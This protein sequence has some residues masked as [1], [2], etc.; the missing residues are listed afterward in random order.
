[1]SHKFK[2]LCTVCGI[3]PVAMTRVEFC[4]HCWPGG[5][6]TPPPCLRCGSRTNYY[7]SGLCTRCHPSATPPVESCRDCL[8]W[9]A[10]RM[11]DWLCRGCNSWRRQHPT[12]RACCICGT[13]VPVDVDGAC[14]LCHRQATMMRVDHQLLDLIGAN[15]D[16]QQLF[17]ADLFSAGSRVRRPRPVQGQDPSPV[18]RHIPAFVQLTLF[19]AAR[20]LAAHGR[21]GLA[22]RCDPVVAA[23]IDEYVAAHAA[24]HGWTPKAT[25]NTA[26]GIRILRGLQDDPDTPIKAS[27]VELLRTIDMDTERIFEILTDT[28]E[29]DD[30][31]VR[32]VDNW[33]TAKTVNLPPKIREELGVWFAVMRDGSTVPPR[34][35]PRSH[36]SINYQL[37]AALPAIGVWVDRGCTTLAE[38]TR[39]D[40]VDVLPIE[41]NPRAACGQGLKSIFAV[42]KQHK[43]VFTNPAAR[44]RTGHPTSNPPLPQDTA[45]LQAAVN[46]TDPAQALIVALIAYHGLRVGALRRIHLT[47]IHDGRLSTANRDIPLAPAVRTRVATYLDQRNSTWPTTANPHLF[48]NSRSAWRTTAVGHRWVQLKIGTELTAQA[49]REDRILNEA[50][51]TRGDTRRLTDLFGLSINAATRYTDTVDHPAFS[52]LDVRPPP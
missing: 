44:V 1:M 32:A 25:I 6:V 41:Q 5:P 16:G 24:R 51:A 35:N 2:T 21:A 40:V 11:H 23:H 30:D 50:H 45:L 13:T 49:I 27:A 8:A 47:E 4:F 52:T 28:R 10:T 14:R 31:R 9:G 17:I 37:N 18:L 7:A 34:R 3:N 36:Y 15:A 48:V 43:L 29:L 39:A 26:V 38:I 22:D 33:F 12:V 19:P 42:L 46:S 20:D